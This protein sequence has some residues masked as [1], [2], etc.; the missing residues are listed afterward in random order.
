MNMFTFQPSKEMKVRVLK[1]QENNLQTSENIKKC[2]EY[3]VVIAFDIFLDEKL[4]GFAMFE[5]VTKRTYFLWDYAIDA[6][7]QNKGYGTKALLALG[8]MMKRDYGIK[9]MTTTYIWGNEHAKHVYEKVGF[10]ETSVI[11]EPDVH[12]VNME[13]VL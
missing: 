13:W 12:E 5:K 1:E 10:I 6:T 7:C 11:D 2:C 3:D 8:E 4:I 9:K